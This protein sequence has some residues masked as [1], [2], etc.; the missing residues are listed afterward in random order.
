MWSIIYKVL[1]DLTTQA[2]PRGTP[3]P[4][5][6]VADRHRG[7]KARPQTFVSLAEP[8]GQMQFQFLT[9]VNITGPGDTT[10]ICLTLLTD[11][12]EERKSSFF[13][14]Q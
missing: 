4:N 7:D 5:Q 8:Q 2:L 13:L 10:R 6:G 11:A 12:Q 3:P 9:L 1:C 14:K